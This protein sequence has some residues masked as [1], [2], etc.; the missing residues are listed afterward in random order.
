[1]PDPV[2]PGTGPTA[3]DA[4]S[5]EEPPPFGASWG[6]LYGVVAGTLAVLIALFVLFTRAFE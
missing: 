4:S 3:T 6:A 5:V 1:M 2:V